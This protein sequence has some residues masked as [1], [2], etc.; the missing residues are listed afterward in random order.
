MKMLARCAGNRGQGR[1]GRSLGIPV[2][3]GQHLGKSGRAQGADNIYPDPDIG[4]NAI[5]MG[6]DPAGQ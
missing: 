5:F 6:A 1:V 2:K 4:E 3:I